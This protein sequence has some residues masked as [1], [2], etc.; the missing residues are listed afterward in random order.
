MATTVLSRL[1]PEFTLRDPAERLNQLLYP[2]GPSRPG[3]CFSTKTESVCRGRIGVL[4][5]WIG[6]TAGGFCGQS[7]YPW[8]VAS[9]FV[10]MRRM[11]LPAERAPAP[12]DSSWWN[13]KKG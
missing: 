5:A 12:E 13:G 11:L 1:G 2:L 4:D 8:K 10:N 9:R 7:A 6:T 3:N